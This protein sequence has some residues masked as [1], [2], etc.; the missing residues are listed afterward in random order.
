ML[1]RIN[2][3]YSKQKEFTANASHELR[4]PI[5]RLIA[6]IENKIIEDKKQNIDHSFHKLL[7]NDAIQLSD[8]TNSLLLLSKLDNSSTI[9]T[10]QCR[11][12]EIVFDA[13]EKTNKLFSDFQMDFEI[14]ETVENVEIFGHN[15]LLNIAFENLFKNCYLYSDNKIAKVEIKDSIDYL[16][17]SISNNGQTLTSDEQKNIFEPFMRGANASGKSGLGLGLRM[18]KRILSQQK[19]SIQ[20]FANPANTFIL[21]FPK[22]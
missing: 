6:Q 7:L 17:V 13:A 9:S 5:S 16:L 4:T 1:E 10:E 19:A 18:V 21:K 3:S 8:L 20:Y 11:I 14:D 12:D 2:Q 15:E 22:K